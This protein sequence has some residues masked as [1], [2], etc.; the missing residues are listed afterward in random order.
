MKSIHF[1][2]DSISGNYKINW[3]WK[4]EDFEMNITIPNGCNAEVI[5][6]DGTI[7]NETGGI[8]YYKCKLDKKIYSPFSIDT[9][10][11]DLFNNDEAKEIVKEYVPQIYQTFEDNDGFKVNSIKSATLLPNFYYSPDTISELNEKLSKI[12][13]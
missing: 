2:Y 4:D 1:S 10:I 8:Y 9:P 7:K 6:P 5:L 12:K 11:I 13:P 3:K